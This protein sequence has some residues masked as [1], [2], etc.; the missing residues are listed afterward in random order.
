MHVNGARAERVFNQ[1][2]TTRSSQA[3]CQEATM[4]GYRFYFFKTLLNSDGHRFK[5]LQGEIEIRN[6]ETEAEA[7]ESASRQF[8]LERGL[9]DWKIYADDVEVRPT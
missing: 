8:A 7:M 5:C 1:R 3:P 9:S 4:T 2:L 6:S